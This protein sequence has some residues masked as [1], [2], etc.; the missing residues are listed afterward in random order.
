MK[1][2]AVRVRR[3]LMASLRRQPGRGI[4]ADVPAGG[5]GQPP[6]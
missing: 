4:F 6:A 3:P 2:A 1:R 5:E